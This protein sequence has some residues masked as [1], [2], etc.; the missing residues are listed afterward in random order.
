MNLF[1]NQYNFDNPC[2][3]A[4]L[5]ENRTTE[6]VLFSPEKKIQSSFILYILL[7][8]QGDYSSKKRFSY[9]FAMTECC[10]RK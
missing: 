4:Q 2:T 7:F 9:H 8:F 10:V 1:K 3:I 6:V 5:L